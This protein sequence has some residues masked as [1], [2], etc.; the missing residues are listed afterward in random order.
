MIKR[1]LSIYI[2]V[3]TVI[4]ILGLVIG[5]VYV[6]FSAQNKDTKLSNMRDLMESRYSSYHDGGMSNYEV[7][8]YE[9]LVKY[10]CTI[11]LVTSSD[12]LSTDMSRDIGTKGGIEGDLYYDTYS[13]RTVEVL[14]FYKNNRKFADTFD[15]AEQC[16]LKDDGSVIAEDS[17]YPLQEGDTYLLFLIIGGKG[18]PLSISG[19]NGN[20]NL[21][22]LRLNDK[23]RVAIEALCDLNILEYDKAYDDIINSLN[24]S[25]IVMFNTEEEVNA[26]YLE[27]EWDTI[28]LTTPYTK[29][30]MAVQLEYAKTNSGYLFSLGNGIYEAVQEDNAAMENTN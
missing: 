21:T 7:F 24:A 27:N 17:C 29:D 16:I 10:A 30:G 5:L 19:D 20:F 11:A 22:Y 6:S 9:G 2:L 23:L 3:P 8:D 26:F 1:K 12:T 18:K 28:A 14:E 15:I 13:L 4:L 25:S